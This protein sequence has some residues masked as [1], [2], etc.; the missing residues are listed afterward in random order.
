VSG[1]GIRLYTDED[2]DT[3]L[4]EQLR[5]LG[6][7]AI[8]CREAD[9]AN[10]GLSDEWQLRYATDEGRAILVH[11]IS[12]FVVL[13]GQWRVRGDEHAGIILAEQSLMLGELVRRTAFHLDI[14]S[15]EY[16]RNAVLYLAPGP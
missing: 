2:V 9:N 15:P 16:Q 6:Y 12:D 1:L 8:S 14:Y 13:D 7:D 5:R 11:N 3:R 4:A 10:R